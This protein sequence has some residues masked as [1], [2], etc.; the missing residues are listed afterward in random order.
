MF[1]VISWNSKN[2][3]TLDREEL[4]V[5]SSAKYVV[6]NGGK[7]EVGAAVSMLFRKDIWGGII[8]SIHGKSIKT[9]SV[10]SSSNTCK[11]YLLNMMKSPSI[12]EKLNVKLRKNAKSECYCV[13]N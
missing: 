1:A 11:N 2:G 10:E 12:L 6:M 8:Q 7:Q 9:D 3:V 5:Q 13:Y 4:E